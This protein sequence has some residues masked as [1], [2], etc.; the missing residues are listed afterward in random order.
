MSIGWTAGEMA[1]QLEM[2]IALSKDRS[3]LRHP[4][5]GS[6]LPAGDSSSKGLGVLWPPGAAA[7]T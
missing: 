2:L 4:P 3:P 1:R 6:R 7:Y 5:G